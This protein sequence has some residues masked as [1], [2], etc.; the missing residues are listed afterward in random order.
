MR[1]RVTGIAREKPAKPEYRLS[2]IPLQG[3]PIQA[4]GVEKPEFVRRPL[5]GR[6]RSLSSLLSVSSAQQL[7]WAVRA[8]SRT[9]SKDVCT[10]SGNLLLPQGPAP[11]R[12]PRAAP[13]DRGPSRGEPRGVRWPP[14]GQPAQVSHP[15]IPGLLPACRTREAVCPRWVHQPIPTPNDPRTGS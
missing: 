9:L 1:M 15:G 14:C 12:A 7:F 5:R 4:D 13:G 2:D 6:S 11:G 8:R 10:N 3:M